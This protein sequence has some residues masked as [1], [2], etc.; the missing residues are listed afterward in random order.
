MGWDKLNDTAW[1]LCYRDD[2]FKVAS[3][4]LRDV[5]DQGN[6]VPYMIYEPS[7]PKLFT[8][9]ETERVDFH[10]LT[11]LGAYKVPRWSLKIDVIDSEALERKLKRLWSYGYNFLVSELCYL[12][13]ACIQC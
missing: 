4:P 2:G 7:I 1:V 12:D 11:T 13:R 10:D 5:R 6:A 3:L 8:P 9:G